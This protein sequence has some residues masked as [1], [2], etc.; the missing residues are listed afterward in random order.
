MTPRLYIL[1]GA[2]GCGK[3][4]L[5]NSIAAV[6]ESDVDPATRAV[7]A[8]KFTERP[9]RDEAGKVDDVIH[10]PQIELG[11][12]DVAYIINNVKYGIKLDPIRQLLARGFSPFIILSDFRVVRQIKEALGDQAK[13]LYISSAIDADRLRRIQLER[14]GFRPTDEQKDVLAYHFSRVSAAARLGW[15]NRV[16]DCMMD[17]E[18]DWHAYATDARS[19]EIR[20]QKIRAFHIRYIEHLDLFDHVILNYSEDRPDEMAD[21]VRALIGTPDEM[22]PISRDARPPVFVVAAASG[23]GKGTLMEMLHLIGRDRVTITSK[24]GKR[25]PKSE[26]RRDGMIALRRTDDA[27]P[28]WPNWWTPAMRDAGRRGEFPPEYDLRWRFHAGTEYAVSS[29]EI[30]RNIAAGMPQILVSN[31]DQFGIFRSRWPKHTVFLYLHRLVSA[32]ENREFQM[33]KWGGDP[34]EAETR[35]AER[36]AVHEAYIRSIASFGHVLLNTSYQEDLHD[37]MFRLLEVYR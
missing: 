32:Q 37:Q 4:T 8:P 29:L 23:A 26:D 36:Q 1:S 3:T 5:L 24:L 16:S 35:I 7:R 2:S 15:W 14:L 13:A 21:Q 11:E 19:T 10:V 30:D 17:L 9:L 28:K 31:M 22:A 27:E 25:A 20:A 12:Y 6:S 33:R 34:A 18:R